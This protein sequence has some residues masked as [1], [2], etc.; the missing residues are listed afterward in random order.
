M[1]SRTPCWSLLSA[2]GAIR[3]SF[4]RSDRV[5]GTSRSDFHPMISST[6]PEQIARFLRDASNM[7]GGAAEVVVQPESEEEVREI[8]RGASSTGTPVTLSAGRTGLSGAAVPMGG[9][10][11]S[12]A[13]FSHNVSIDREA[14]T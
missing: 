3:D 6:D 5:H 8:M 1:A 4:R 2:V 7:P 14:H 13:R 9:I 11:L 10:V 12:L